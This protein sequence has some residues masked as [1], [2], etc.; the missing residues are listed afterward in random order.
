MSYTAD[1]LSFKFKYVKNGNPQGIFAQ[2]ATASS[3]EIILGKERLIYEDIADSTT[4]DN[5]LILA[6]YPTASLSENVSQQLMESSILVLEVYQINPLNLERFIDRISSKKQTEIKR[7]ELI[8]AGQG[9]LFRAVTC[10]E[11]QATIHLSGLNKTSYIYCRFC[12]SIFQ[13]NQSV[14]TKGS[15]YPVCDECHMFDRVRGYTEFYFYFLLVIYGFYH[16]RRHLCDNCANRV[17]WKTFILNFLFIVGIIPSIWIKI[18]SMTGRNP[19]LK[20]LAK[21]NALAKRGKYEQADLIYQQ[22]Y[23]HYFNHP[24]LLMNEGLGHLFG[25]DGKGVINCFDRSLS[26]CSNY[27]P[28]IS[29]M[30]QIQVASQDKQE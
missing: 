17:F 1:E 4:R 9:N 22:L 28:V 6:I 3:E 23:E 11:C 18:K 30:Q 19:A 21:A 20:Q 2:K 15:E 10:P 24:G 7:Q 26:S 8:Q 16:K 12:E 13:E 25:N 14:M 5:R 29:L 27:S